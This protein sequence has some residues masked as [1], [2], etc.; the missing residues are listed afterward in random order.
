MKAAQLAAPVSRILWKEF[1]AQR[2][3]WLACLGIGFTIMLVS[4][5]SSQGSSRWSDQPA[6]HAVPWGV[7]VMYVIGCAAMLFARERE[8]RT[9]E[10]LLDLS[11]PALPT[12]AAKV[13]FAIVSA[14]CLQSTLTLLEWSFSGTINS[15]WQPHQLFSLFIL[16]VAL[17][18]SLTSRRVLSSIA[19]MAFWTAITIVVPIMVTRTIAVSLFHSSEST[20]TIGEQAV[21]V[22]L[23]CVV[24]AFEIWVGLNWCRGCYLDASAFDRFAAVFERFWQRWFVFGAAA[25][26]I[27]ATPELEQP[28]RR[29]WQRLIWQERYRETLQWL[30]LG[31]FCAIGPLL[32]AIAEPVKCELTSSYCWSASSFRLG[33]E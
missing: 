7:G 33:W 25:S 16:I 3:L 26:R 21:L 2:A 4:S 13:L 32:A 9:S 28:W 18:G 8:E 24:V 14:I 10:W 20:T 30:L 23:W 19:A 27:P 6:Y 31:A 12:F 15:W 29:T 1:R 5:Y 17:L 22:G 11:V